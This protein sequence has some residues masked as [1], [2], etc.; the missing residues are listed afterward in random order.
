MFVGGFDYFI[1]TAYFNLL[2]I[3]L[4][5]GFRTFYKIVCPT[6]GKPRNFI[7]VY[8]GILKELQHSRYYNLMEI[9]R[10]D[11]NACLHTNGVYTGGPDHCVPIRAG[12][13]KGYVYGC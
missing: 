9:L 10:K 11:R 6:K 7:T 5:N 4:E 2:F 3:A 8:D 1:V 12:L 13:N